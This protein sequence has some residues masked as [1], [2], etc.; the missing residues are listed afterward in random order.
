MRL[1]V[2][3][4][5]ELLPKGE[6]KRVKVARRVEKESSFFEDCFVALKRWSEPKLTPHERKARS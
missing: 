5:G 6:R 2:A 4:D 1:F 3:S